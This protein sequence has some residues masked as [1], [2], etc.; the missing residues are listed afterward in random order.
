MEII[1]K[2]IERIKIISGI[3]VVVGMPILILY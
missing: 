1:P 2:L 3:F